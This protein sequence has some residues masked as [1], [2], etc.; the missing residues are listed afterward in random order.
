MVLNA[1]IRGPW[2]NWQQLALPPAG[3]PGPS[4]CQAVLG[5][6]STNIWHILLSF[7]GIL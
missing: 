1:L 6:L 7:Q 4:D 5:I 3:L 2:L